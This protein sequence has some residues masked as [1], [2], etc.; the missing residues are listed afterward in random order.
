[1]IW[2]LCC[3]SRGSRHHSDQARS[4]SGIVHRNGIAALPQDHIDRWRLEPQKGQGSAHNTTC[5]ESQLQFRASP[6]AVAV[7]RHLATVGVRRLSKQCGRC[8]T[9]VLLAHPDAGRQ[10][11]EAVLR[12]RAAG[13]VAVPCR[14]GPRFLV[15]PPG[16]SVCLGG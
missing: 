16:K 15:V 4:V 14:P 9:T 13:R 11:E 5:H 3:A 6:K 10:F 8:R 1:M 2:S 7:H 12:R